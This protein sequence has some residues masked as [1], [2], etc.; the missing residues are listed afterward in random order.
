M[1]QKRDYYD[2][3]DVSRDADEDEIKKAYRKLAI[4]YHPDKNPDNKEAEEKF[5]EATEA[6]DVLRTPEK[7]QRYDQFG[8][9]GLEGAS[10]GYDFG[11][12]LDD[13]FSEVFGD[14]FGGFGRTQNRPKQGRSLQYN[15]ELSLEDAFNGKEVTIEVPRI[16]S[17]PECS[18]SGAERGTTVETCPQC[19]GR[20][21]VT[22][23]QGFFTMSRPCPRC[24]GEGEI[25]QS[26]CRNCNGQGRIRVKRDIK[27]KI[28]KGV[29]N[30]FEYRLRGEGESGTLGGPSGDLLVVIHIQPNQR[31]SRDGN[32]LI[33]SAKI[34]FVQAA[35]GCTIEINSLE[36]PQ[37]LNIPAGTQYGDKVRL[38]G[39]GM[40]KLRSS[41]FGD[42][43]VQVGIET[44]KKLNEQQ[45]KLLEH[46][47]E[48][49]DESIESGNKGFWDKLFHHDD[50]DKK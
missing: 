49:H 43:V 50:D 8:H 28:D 15:L 21:Q 33:T 48:L 30:G 19:Y 2:I 4:K 29:D 45:R 18:G 32:D 38:H 10:S 22:Q 14:V 16:E 34:S 25:V 27:L 6:Y 35:L 12:N 23:S 20:G 11:V 41:S 40:P 3:L 31:F 39:K 13:I 1:V 44:P 24:R 17:C 9:A 5:K 37:K 46:F 26:P 7:R 47:A 42:L 36:G